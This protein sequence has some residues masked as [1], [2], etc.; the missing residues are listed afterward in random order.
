MFLY[1][2][3][4]SPVE[5]LSKVLETKLKTYTPVGGNFVFNK[6]EFRFLHYIQHD[7]INGCS[8]RQVQVI[9]GQIETVKF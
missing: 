7:F 8:V 6:I 4:K 1:T 9:L 3:K 2:L 5:K